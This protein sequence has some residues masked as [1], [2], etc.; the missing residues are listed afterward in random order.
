[1]YNLPAQAFCCFLKDF[2]QL[3]TLE[4]SKQVVVLASGLME[5]FPVN[6]GL[7]QGDG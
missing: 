4:K 2:F 5:I 1:M 7:L 6:F 3:K